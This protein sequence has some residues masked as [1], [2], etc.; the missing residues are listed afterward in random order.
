MRQ[1]R[2]QDVYSPFPHVLS[3]R[4][5]SLSLSASLFIHYFL[6]F[7]FSAIEKKTTEIWQIFPYNW[8]PSIAAV[9]NCVWSGSPWREVNGGGCIQRTVHFCCSYSPNMA[10][11]FVSC[12]NSTNSHRLIGPHTSCVS[13]R[14]YL[15]RILKPPHNISVQR[16]ST[17]PPA[18]AFLPVARFCALFYQDNNLYQKLY[19]ENIFT[20]ESNC[21]PPSGFVFLFQHTSQPVSLEKV[22]FSPSLL[23]PAI[24]ISPAASRL[25]SHYSHFSPVLLF[26]CINNAAVSPVGPLLRLVSNNS[27]RFLGN[28]L[29][30]VH[31]GEGRAAAGGGTTSG[32][33]SKTRR[34]SKQIKEAK[35]E[36]LPFPCL[37]WILYQGLTSWWECPPVA[38]LTSSH[39]A[40]GVCRQS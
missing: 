15:L 39:V 28:D 13:I 4:L 5:S 20:S 22:K 35:S 29:R 8:F 25:A 23:L 19:I 30:Y 14:L 21:L 9:R 3:L 12:T 2:C 36:V 1:D 38:S 7:F 27:T 37:A 18:F 6:R 32:R 33:R 11:M 24:W 34:E 17:F 40:R 26:A 16:L 31:P 10:V